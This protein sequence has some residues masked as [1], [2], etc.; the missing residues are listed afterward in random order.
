MNLKQRCIVKFK[1]FCNKSGPTI[2][3]FISPLWFLN[4]VIGV[5]Y[6]ADTIIWD[7]LYGAGTWMSLTAKCIST[8]MSFEMI[9][10]W[11]FLCTVR[12]TYVN[13]EDNNR[14]RLE[15]EKNFPQF[16]SDGILYEELKERRPTLGTGNW[17]VITHHKPEGVTRTAYPYWSWKP[18]VVCSF[19]KPPRCHHCPMCNECVLKRDHHCFFARQCIGLYNQRFFVVFNFWSTCLTVLVA[20]Q[21]IYYTYSAL[22]PTM[23]IGDLFLPWTLMRFIL[24]FTPFYTFYIILQVYSIIFFILTA[25]TFLYEQIKCIDMG[26]TSFETDNKAD[27]IKTEC[28]SRY[29]KFACVFGRRPI[30]INFLIPFHWMSPPADDGISWDT[31]KK[32]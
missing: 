2:L 8:F 6:V 29:E 10:N 13:T 20:P 32:E 30:I 18:C 5:N 9:I 17:S 7:Y 1:V 4:C 14:K 16:N 11:I 19:H 31:M 21:I 25:G 24:G 23:T 12:S 22:W 26:L 3:N 15:H 28:K 27:D